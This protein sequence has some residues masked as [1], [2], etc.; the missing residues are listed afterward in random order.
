MDDI[1]A[2]CRRPVAPDGFRR[3]FRSGICA[4][5]DG[6]EQ[7]ESRLSD[8]CHFDACLFERAATRRETVWKTALTGD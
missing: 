8:I 1:A 6:P 4:R 3:E 5:P 2:P 7:P